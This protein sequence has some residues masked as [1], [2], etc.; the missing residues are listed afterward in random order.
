M[1]LLKRFKVYASIMSLFFLAA[2]CGS[3]AATSSAKV[4]INVWGL[5]DTN[6]TF[7]SDFAAAYQKKYPNVKITYTEKNVATYEAD[8]INAMAA[9]TGPDIFY[10]HNDWLP[11][12]KDKIQPATVKDWAISDYG[13]SFADVASK[14]F[15]SAGQVYAVPLSI[16]TLV[17]YYNKDILGSFGIAEPPKT[18][19]ELSAD[20]QKIAEKNTNGYF[21]RSGIALGTSANINRAQDITYLLMLQAGTIPFNSDNTRSTID[22]AISGSS[23]NNKFPGATALNYYTSFSNSLSKSYDWNTQSDYSLDAF[24]NGN[25]AMMYGYY[26][27]EATILQK[28]PNLNFGVAPVPQPA[29]D[30]NLVNYSNYWGYTVSKQSKVANWDWDFLKFISSNSQLEAYNKTNPQ[31]SSRKDIIAEQ[32]TDTKL[33]VVASSTLTAKSFYKPDAVQTDSIITNMIDDISLRDKAVTVALSS[34]SQQLTVLASKQNS[35]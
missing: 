35:N 34:A 28:S 13:N 30:Q 23:G 32:V 17:L 2:G 20:A 9:G 15:I 10:I 33:G 12:Y 18:W 21:N 11:T 31:P 27:D 29:L 5:F 7:Q 3:S 6:S 1:K 24:A 4:S 16:D 8:L 14:D 26:Y 19:S 25:L 22:Q